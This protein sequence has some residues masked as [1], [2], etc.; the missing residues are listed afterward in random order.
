MREIGTAVGSACLQPAAP[1]S[2]AGNRRDDRQGGWPRC[3][4]T[5]GA[6]LV[7]KRLDRFNRTQSSYRDDGAEV[8]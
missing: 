8:S 5:V 7:T 4:V 6:G 2:A 3:A 1:A